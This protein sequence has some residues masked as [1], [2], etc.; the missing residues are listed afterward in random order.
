MTKNVLIIV[1]ITFLTPLFL[2]AQWIPLEGKAVKIPPTVTLLS[3]DGQSTII[4]VELSG[5]EMREIVTDG[6]TYQS[7]S[8]LT[9]M[10][11]IEEGLAE[12]PYIAEILAIPDQ[13]SATIEILEVGA[14]EIFNN[15][16]LP[17]ARKSW[18]EGD[19]EPPYIKDE[20]AYKS[21]NLYPAVY[22]EMDDPSILRDFRISR[23]AVYP[24]RYNAEKSEVHVAASITV[25]VNY[26]KGEVINPKTSRKNPIAPSFAELYRSSIFNYQEVLNEHY[27]GRED[28]REVML[29][30]MPDMFTASFQIYADWKRESGTDIHITKF[31]DIG[32]NGSNPDIIKNHITQAYTNWENPPTY[33]LIVGDNGIFPK[34]I[35]TYPGY[36]FAWEEFFVAVE[37]NDYFPEMMIG[38]FTNQEDYRM[39]VMINKFMLY[40]KQPYTSDPSW[41]KKGLCC[42]N[43][44]Y[45]SQVETKRFA[46]KVM[47]E[48]GLFTSVDTMMSDGNGWG[49][50]CTYGISHIKA[51]INEGRSY[52]N[53]RGEGWSYGWYANC[54]DFNTSDVSSLNNGQKFTFVTSIGCG[55]AM[56]DASGGNCWGEE[57]IQMGSLTNPRGGIGFIGPTSNTHTTY[58]NRIDKGIYVGMFREGMD[59]PGQAMARGKL[60]MY[61]VFGNV[62]YVEYHYKVFCVLGDPSIHIWKDVPLNVTANYPETIPV[63]HSDVEFT[64]THTATGLP[65]NNA[66]VTIIGQDLFFSRFTDETGKV[67]IDL[68]PEME[69]T[70]KVT[71]R[72]G[73]VIPF[74]GTMGVIQ[75]DELVEPEGA[76]AVQ[77]LDGNQDGLINPNETCSIQFQLKNW[78]S[79]TASNVSAVLSSQDEYIQVLSTS[80]V[81]YGSILPGT[82]APGEPFQFFIDPS[83]PVGHTIQLQLH[84]E[85]AIFS[86]D[87]S[88]QI[89]VTG[90]M[91]DF[92]N[93]AVFDATSP[94][95]NF[96]ADAGETVV[97]VL[98][99]ANHGQDLAPEVTGQLFSSDPYIQ[100]IDFEGYF[101]SLAINGMAINTNEHFVVAID[102]NCPAGHLAA[103]TLT[104][105]TQNG[106]YPYQK[107]IDIE[108]PVGTSVPKDYTGPDAYG[109]YAYSSDDTFYDETPEFEWVEIHETGTQI[110]VPPIGDYTKTIDLPFTFKYYGNDFTKVRV[111]TDGWIA[112]GSGTQTAPVNTALPAN[113]NVNNMVA[114]MWDDL[115][116]EEFYMG[117]F[118]YHYDNQNHR[119]II[120][121]DSISHANFLEEPVREVFQVQ[122]LDPSHHITLTGDGE[123]VMQYKLVQQPETVT[124]G[125]ENSTQDVG[126]TYVFNNN[127]NPTATDLVS[128]YAVK[129]TTDPPFENMIVG[130]K[131]PIARAENSTS[132]TNRP[133]PFSGHTIVSFNLKQSE[134]VDLAIYDFNGKLIKNL[135]NASMAY[136]QHEIVWN[137]KNEAGS[138]VNP[139]VY[140]CRLQAGEISETIKILII[141]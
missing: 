44:D 101:G 122:L 43:N 42:S 19:P 118:F 107:S 104:L 109:Y 25:K 129:F 33:V 16:Q 70:L 116:D 139:G 58:N 37:G 41:F 26:G 75:A 35:V 17:P 2:L 99:I 84:V 63:G 115:Y 114:V 131:T 78:G 123:I 14:I 22:A 111:S 50:G 47:L 71:V 121:W 128:T 56:F 66:Q 93:I 23:L 38:R 89:N 20:N 117:N 87:Y 21:G 119:F 94:A 91:L 132:L 106:N 86:W 59:T 9:E 18:W 54:Y 108:L 15:I 92:E 1:L 140:F 96:K 68:M 8:L 120:Q 133:N 100:I 48:D 29:C 36:S 60:Y 110:L 7:V 27:N 124:V 126:L 76:P 24:V 51:A 61:N 112:F 3:S 125:I 134:N 10:F 45:E 73:N 81:S 105:A 62:Y 5:F 32:A 79:T 77:D 95:P 102:E 130:I 103:L 28:G 113:D 40:E 46:A 80:P 65:V 69:E 31:S 72:G 57:W 85:S 135:L 98:Q 90:C 82:V 30:I 13:A 97:L 67:V 39:Q 88:H 83:C 52:L 49:Q 12:I 34:K 4:K 136:G 127:Y 137:G 64:I 138:A 11:T 74:Q 55:V 53:Y 141:R 6:S